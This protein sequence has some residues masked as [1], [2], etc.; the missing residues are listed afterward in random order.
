MTKLIAVLFAMALVPA[1]VYAVDG[2]ILINQATV[3]AAGGFPYRITASGSYKLSGNLTQPTD[4]VDA[5]QIN[6]NNVVLDLNG[7]T[8]TGP[9]ASSSLTAGTCGSNILG[10]SQCNGIFSVFGDVT[11]KN[12]SITGFASAVVLDNRARVTEIVANRNFHSIYILDGTIERSTA[13]SNLGTGISISRGKVSESHA[14]FNTGPGFDVV[15][16]IITGNV[17]M[18]NGTGI[19]AEHSLVGNNIFYQN[20]TGGNT[21]LQLANGAISQGNNLCTNGGC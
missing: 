5:I 15:Q 17:A 2:Q 1:C 10:P 11:V 3:M 4:G 14:S 7:F 20:G 13:D 21:D 6:A 8:I 18:F 16:A 19:H 12:G 9:G